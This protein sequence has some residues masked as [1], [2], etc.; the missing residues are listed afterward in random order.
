RFDEGDFLA[1][2]HRERQLLGHRVVECRIR[3]L[4]DLDA[5]DEL[6][7]RELE[8]GGRAIAVDRVAAVKFR[9]DCDRVRV[10][11][12]VDVADGF[13][14]TDVEDGY[15]VSAA[16]YEKIASRRIE[17]DVIPVGRGPFQRNRGLAQVELLRL[18]RSGER[19]DSKCG[20][21]E[22]W[23]HKVSCIHC[24]ADTRS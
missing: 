18:D 22:K 20:G 5:I 9:N 7:R 12:L 3:I 13:F 19:D 15:A 1:V 2:A 14:R 24:A 6:K 17:S 8:D 23:F 16:P 10:L 4:A 21:S 11:G